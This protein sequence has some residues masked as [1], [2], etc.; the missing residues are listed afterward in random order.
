MRPFDKRTREELLQIIEAMAEEFTVA[1]EEHKHDAVTQIQGIE[2]GDVADINEAI[3][4][5]VHA[6][7][8]L[9]LSQQLR[10][11]IGIAEGRRNAA[12]WIRP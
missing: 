1:A 8:L 12:R 4:R 5:S 11:I 6:I 3:H 2:R 7:A 10:E 9:R